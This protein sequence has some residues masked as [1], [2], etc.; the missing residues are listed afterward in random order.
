MLAGGEDSAWPCPGCRP[1]NPPHCWGGCPAPAHLAPRQW[2]L[3]P[4]GEDDDDEGGKMNSASSEGKGQF[5]KI[6]APSWWPQSLPLAAV[7]AFGVGRVG[8]GAPGTAG[9]GPRAGFCTSVSERE[10]RTWLSARPAG[11]HLP[12]GHRGPPPH[13]SEVAP[14]PGKVSPPA[15]PSCPCPSV[16]LVAGVRPPEQ[17]VRGLLRAPQPS[18]GLPGS[19][20]W[21][22]AAARHPPSPR[23]TNPDVTFLPPFCSRP[24]FL[25][26]AA[27][28][29][30]RS[31]PPY[32]KP[33]SHG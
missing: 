16:L 22:F 15:C 32:G 7:R 17:G 30:A 18:P 33:R 23:H 24:S 1:Y 21:G 6:A 9:P 13:A 14:R 3:F 26:P 27:R 2:G 19:P 25:P 28:P 4:S 8:K 11:L 5:I 31:C 10:G 29:L 20:F 12:P